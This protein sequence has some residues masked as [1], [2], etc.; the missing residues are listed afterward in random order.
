VSGGEHKAYQEV[1]T[2]PIAQV[3]QAPEIVGPDG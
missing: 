2:Q 3:A 1:V